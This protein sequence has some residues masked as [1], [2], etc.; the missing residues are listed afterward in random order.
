MEETEHKY[1]ATRELTI[2]KK[3]EK[4][5]EQAWGEWK[6][7]KTTSNISL[8][9]WQCQFSFKFLISWNPSVPHDHRSLNPIF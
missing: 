8:I 3:R 2:N 1:K 6:E 5:K 9:R 7:F 4:K